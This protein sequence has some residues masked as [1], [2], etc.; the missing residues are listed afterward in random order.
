[1][2]ENQTMQIQSTVITASDALS[3]LI[4]NFTSFVNL[5]SKTMPKREHLSLMGK[6][7]IY[8]RCLAQVYV[9]AKGIKAIT[10]IGPEVR[11]LLDYMDILYTAYSLRQRNALETFELDRSEDGKL[12]LKIK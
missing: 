9:K 2:S 11:N 1:M 7:D 3:V 12:S 8:M 6:D 5:V 10:V 4:E